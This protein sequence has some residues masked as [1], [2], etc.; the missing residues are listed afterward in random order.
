MWS[1]NKINNLIHLISVPQ[2]F[3][4]QPLQA[5]HC[6][7]HWSVKA[8]RWICYPSQQ[9]TTGTGNKF[10]VKNFKSCIFPYNILLSYEKVCLLECL[11]FK[12]KKKLNNSIINYSFYKKFIFPNKPK[13]EDKT[14]YR[15]GKTSVGLNYHCHSNWN[16]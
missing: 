5:N 4:E 2:I 11:C 12:M 16:T 14:K 10:K 9:K 1:E 7:S 6:V 8:K 3:T 13:L 15:V